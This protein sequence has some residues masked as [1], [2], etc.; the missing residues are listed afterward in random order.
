MKTLRTADAVR[1]RRMTAEE[2]RSHFLIS[3]LFRRDRAELVY[4]DADR[5]LVGGVMPVA[6]RLRLEVGRELAADYI[7]QRREM[8]V[9][10]IGGPG[11]VSVDGREFPLANRECLYIGRGSREIEFASESAEQPARMFLLS[12]PA[13][14][15][16]PTAKATL[17]DAR[18]VEVGAAATAN[19]RTIH[20]FI[21]EGGLRSC[22][23]VMGFTELHEGSV[24]NTFPPHRH[25]RR[26]EV[27]CYFDLPANGVVLHV[28]GEPEDTRHIVV[29]EGEAVVSPAW[30][31]HSGVGTGAYR[32]V[33]G[34]GG[35]NQTFDDMDPVDLATLA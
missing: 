1:Y 27:Y 13:H 19:R 34:M 3:G 35:E 29:R 14:A 26:T 18:R 10:N 20:Q 2:L 16:Y 8:G 22:Q 24:W 12:Y 5:A 9:I 6:K 4:T 15:A 30:S 25:D 31:I 33:W 21:H 28:L 17:A 23:L 11:R 32:F 7:C